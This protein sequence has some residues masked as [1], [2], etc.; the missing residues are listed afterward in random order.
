M[1][2][3]P[4][5]LNACEWFDRRYN[6]KPWLAPV[7]SGYSNRDNPGDDDHAAHHHVAAIPY[8][9]S[10]TAPQSNPNDYASPDDESA[11]GIRQNLYH[12]NPVFRYSGVFAF[13]SIQTFLQQKII[14]G[15]V[16]PPFQ[17]G[18]TKHRFTKYL[19]VLRLDDQFVSIFAFLLF[20]LYNTIV[21][22]F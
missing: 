7:H 12:R 2:N 10:D 17:S 8:T 18:F 16:F 4:A 1:E 22:R 19:S 6:P 5:R 14:P 13:F 15:F 9:E 11:K 3:D 21:I 20:I